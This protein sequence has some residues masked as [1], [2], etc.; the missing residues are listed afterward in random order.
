[1]GSR[2]LN[3]MRRLLPLSLLLLI[4]A[5]TST[6]NVFVAADDDIESADDDEGEVQGGAGE[7]PNDPNAPVEEG[8]EGGLP[9]ILVYKSITSD[10]VVD[11]D[12]VVS[13]QMFNVGDEP[14]YDVEV[15]DSNGFDAKQF[16]AVSGEPSAKF[17]SIEAGANVTH[18][19]TLK[20]NQAEPFFSQ[21][22]LIKYGA[23]AGDEDK[24]VTVSSNIGWVRVQTLAQ[25]EST[26]SSYL[27]TQ[28]V[29]YASMASIPVVL[30][31]IMYSLVPLESN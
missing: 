1:M 30:P 10:A 14:A 11:K 26:D 16:E 29:T 27:W 2:S 6:N 4:I 22:A 7:D 15:D 21:P 13:L 17:E 25:W 28:W 3:M 19:Y 20:P 31:A 24:Q 9:N 18:I 8:T 5:M 12:M 23:A